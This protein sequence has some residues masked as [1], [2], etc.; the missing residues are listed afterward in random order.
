MKNTNDFNV[1]ANA[2]EKQKKQ[3]EQEREKAA[4]RKRHEDIDRIQNLKKR[5]E[6]RTMLNVRDN[7]LADERGRQEDLIQRAGDDAVSRD[8]LI[9]HKFEQY[10][11]E[12]EDLVRTQIR[13]R[14]ELDFAPE[15]KAI[16]Q[17]LN[18]KIDA[19]VQKTLE[20]ERKAAPEQKQTSFKD[21]LRQSYSE[22]SRDKKLSRDVAPS[23]ERKPFD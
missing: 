3:Y 7:E 18:R 14:M 4:A 8:R 19:F 17:Q 20:N 22:A 15:N 12:R 1:S 21:R 9:N 5:R 13:Q 6:A 23:R 11:P 10:T 16:E 2:T